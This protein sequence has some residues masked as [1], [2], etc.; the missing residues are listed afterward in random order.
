MTRRRVIQHAG[1]V[2]A[3]SMLAGTGIAQAQGEPSDEQGTLSVW[4][5]TGADLNAQLPE[6]AADR[7]GEQFPNVEMDL[8]QLQNDPFKTRL[9]VALGSDNPPDIW[10]SWGGGVLGEYV[11]DGVVLE[12]TDALNEDGWIDRF[13][14]GLLDLMK[15]GDGYYGVPIVANTV[16]V[17]FNQSLL[18]EVTPPQNWDEFIQFVTD[19]R[20]DGLVPLTLANSTAWPGAFYLNYLVLRLKGADFLEQVMAGEASFEDPAVVQ[21]GEMMQQLADAGAFPEGF[22]GLDIDTGGSRQLLYAEQAA[23]ELM[24]TWLPGTIESE[25]PGWSENLNFFEFPIIDGGEGDPTAVLGGVSPAYAASAATEVPE[26]AI[27]FLK[28]ITDDTARDQAV[29]DGRLTAIKGATYED[30][31]TNRLATILEEAQSVQLFWDQY[32]P[33]E[34]GQAQLDV[35][36][37]LLGKSITPEEGAS[38]LEQAAASLRSS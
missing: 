1:L 12:L 4:S 34:L 7:I 14:P 30:E 20:A 21:A 22:N 18:G 29:A 13:A 32:L 6:G 5:L 11:N 17:W 3:G 35:S 37:A 2:G 9:R 28:A 27:A 16:V 25:V 26:A 23:M 31:M 19:I 8:Q 24:G 15:V 38:Q 36:Q 10:H 33:P